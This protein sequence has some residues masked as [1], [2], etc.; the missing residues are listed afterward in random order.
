MIFRLLQYVYYMIMVGMVQSE[1]QQYGDLKDKKG[2]FI[3]AESN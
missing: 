3:E 2:K 1:V